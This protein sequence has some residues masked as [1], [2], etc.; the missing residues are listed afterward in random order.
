[1]SYSRVTVLTRIALMSTAIFLATNLTACKT[2]SNY[3]AT[4]S[5]SVGGA[6]GSTV[7]VT[8]G[9]RLRLKSKTG[10]PDAFLHKFGDVTAGCEITL[11]NINTPTAIQC[12]LN[13][14]EY[15]LW[16]YG[17][18]TELSVPTS[19]CKYV[20]DSPMRY[21]VAR[22][23]VGIKSATMSTLN[24]V[25]QSCTIDGVAGVVSA[26]SCRGP[27]GTVNAAGSATCTYDYTTGK[28]PNCCAGSASVS[29][30]ASVTTVAPPTTTVT[31][32]TTAFGGS[33]ANCRLSA[34]D[35]VD[36]WPQI[37][38]EQKAAN[39]IYDVGGSSFLKA[40]KL[41]GAEGLFIANKRYFTWSNV[42]NAGFNDWTS[43]TANPATWLTT[44]TF[45]IA[46]K[47]VADLGPL[48]DSAILNGADAIPLAS[49]GS[50]TFNCHNEAGEI[51]HQIKLFVNEWNTVEDYAAFKAGGSAASV[52]PAKQGIAGVNC[53]ALNDG[54]SCNS[55]WGFDDIRLQQGATVYPMEWQASLPP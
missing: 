30:T 29:L 16:F 6:D 37:S 39:I 22:P 7:D 43:Y 24:G 46:M 5:A 42:L 38:P 52:D 10:G 49:D 19:I 50:E 25:V 20:V 12:M 13:M 11:A 8:A 4:D 40:T 28:G 3:F 33:M 44:H 18:E 15:D 2:D 31:N 53:T 51:K 45:P 9:F 23:G 32:V 35:F 14:M 48:G 17:F 1:M 54:R 36:K 41:K 55:L 27:E 47:P 34:H 26:G 21:Y